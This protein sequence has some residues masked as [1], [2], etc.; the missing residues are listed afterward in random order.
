M[1]NHILIL[2][3][4][5]VNNDFLYQKMMHNGRMVSQLV[6]NTNEIPKSENIPNNN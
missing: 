3:L 2:L 5:H 4:F 1:Q 6:T